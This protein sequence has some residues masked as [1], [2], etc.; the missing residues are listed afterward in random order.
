MKK[1][2]ILLLLL[3]IACGGSSEETVVEDTTTTTVQDTTTTTVQDTTTTTIQDTTTTTIQDTTT[4]TIQESSYQT[5]NGQ[6]LSHISERFLASF[7][8]N[9]DGLTDLVLGRRNTVP[10]KKA[11]IKVYFNNGDGTFTDATTSVLTSIPHAFSPIGATADFNNDGILDIAI[12][13]QG[14]NT[15]GQMSQGGYIGGEPILL[16]SNGTKWNVSNAFIDAVQNANPKY[17]WPSCS[18]TLHAK[19]ITTGDIDNDGDIDLYIE[20]GGGYNN[21]TPHFMIN[22]GDAT[23]HID[24]SDNRRSDKLIWGDTGSH[25]FARQ[26]LLDI[27][28]DGYLDLV[29]GQLRRIDNGQENLSSMIIFNDGNGNFLLGNELKLPYVTWNDGWTYVKNIVSADLNKD[30]LIDLILSHE[31]GNLIPDPENLGNTGRYLQ[32]LIQQK[33]GNFIDESDSWFGNQEETTV[34]KINIQENEITNFN[35]VSDVHYIDI[36]RDSE[37][38]L[39]FTSDQ[40]LG[41]HAPLIMLFENFQFVPVDYEDIT[42]GESWW[43]QYSFPIDLNGNGFYDFIHMD[44]NIGLDNIWGNEDDYSLIIPTFI[45]Y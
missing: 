16:L 18:T 26:K 43:G 23:F 7:D 14:D 9:N 22:N 4:T 30:G 10:D 2:L 5:I 6:K 29:M 24:A 19:S 34:S 42:L 31:R 15:K 1:A 11:P 44:W 3:I 35:G 33:N 38:D 8:M 17:C 28:E 37:N 13:D 12:I 40:Q 39:F 21:P 20:S 45:N 25:R 36:N 27:N 32:A 41:S